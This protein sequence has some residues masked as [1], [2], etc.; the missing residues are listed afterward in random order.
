MCALEP[1]ILAES[2]P[3]GTLRHCMLWQPYLSSRSV[4]ALTTYGVNFFAVPFVSADQTLHCYDRSLPKWCNYYPYRRYH[5]LIQTKIA[6]DQPVDRQPRH[7]SN[8]LQIPKKHAQKLERSNIRATALESTP[9]NPFA[10]TADP[11]HQPTREE[12]SGVS[13]CQPL[14]RPGRQDPL[15]ANLSSKPVVQNSSLAGGC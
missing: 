14:T 6:I 7:P 10:Y 8:T 3:L 11:P 15:C 13:P 4:Q 1:T 9:F 5:P 12:L 2:M